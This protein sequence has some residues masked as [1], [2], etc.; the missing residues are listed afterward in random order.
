MILLAFNQQSLGQVGRVAKVFPSGDVRVGVNGMM[1]TFNPAC[2]IPAPEEYA[3][4][5]PT[6]KVSDGFL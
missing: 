4:K 6:S 3:P 5:L 2:L 1:W